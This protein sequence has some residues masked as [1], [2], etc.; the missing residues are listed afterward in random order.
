MVLVD[1]HFLENPTYIHIY[2]INIEYIHIYTYGMYITHIKYNN[3]GIQWSIEEHR[4]SLSY[5]KEPLLYTP[6]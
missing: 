5:V 1:P 3:V 2:I 6:I 4:N